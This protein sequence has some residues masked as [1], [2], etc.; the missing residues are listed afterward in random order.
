VLLAVGLG[1]AASV[2]AGAAP[3][4]AAP[5]GA[6]PRAAASVAEPAAEPQRTTIEGERRTIAVGE[7]HTFDETDCPDSHPWVFNEMYGAA[8]WRVTPGVEI[9]VEEGRA[10]D[11]M[12]DIQ[13]VIRAPGHRSAIGVGPA[14]LNRVRLTAGEPVAYRVDVH[15]TS[16]INDS[17][18]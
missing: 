15:C 9:L 14:S 7:E 2:P 6:A 3:A 10:G 11:L 16:D 17:Y 1:V 4:G 8:P 12:V 18:S 13:S 5:A